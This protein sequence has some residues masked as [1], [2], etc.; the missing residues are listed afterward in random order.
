M[1]VDEPVLTTSFPTEDLDIIQE[2]YEAL[3]Q[4]APSLNIVLQTYFGSLD[5]YE[6][7]STLPVQGIGLDF[8]HD[9]GENLEHVLRH[10][11][12]AGKTLVPLVLLTGAIYGAPI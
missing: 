8:V 12:P 9:D 4:A 3:A 11:F 10:G 2:A 5:H 6:R 7:L 1:Q